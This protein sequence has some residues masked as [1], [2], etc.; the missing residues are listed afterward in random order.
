MENTKTPLE[1]INQ[2]TSLS[3]NTESEIEFNIGATERVESSNS[4]LK[5]KKSLLEQINDWTI[6]HSPVSMKEKVVF[7]RLLATMINAGVTLNKAIHILHDQT[8]DAK[9]QRV[10][11]DIAAQLEKGASLSE[12]LKI[13]PSVF[14]EAEVGMISSGEVSGKLNEVL[15]DLAQRVENSSKIKGKIRGAMMY[16]AAIVVVLIIV[17]V[18]VLVMVIPKLKDTFEKGGA[19]LPQATQ[20]LINMSESIM[21]DTYGIPNSIFWLVGIIVFFV[22][23]LAWKKTNEGKYYWDYFTLLIPVFGLLKR[24]VI[25]AQFC[26]SLSSLTK[27]GV[28]IVRTLKIIS[29]VVGNEVYRRR[30]LLIAED[31]KQGIPIADNIKEN[32]SMFPTMLTSMISVGEQTAELD[33]VSE[34]IAEFY[35]GEV[36]TMV[37]G[38]TSMMEPII[39]LVIGSVVGFIVIAIMQPIMSISEVASN[40]S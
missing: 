17:V 28:S 30:I 31:V 9:M 35:E 16:P 20:I 5:P 26:R 36:D 10:C 6:E 40:A 14:A 13:Y 22:L 3:Q 11:G 4:V 32:V 34:K 27:S 2:S 19:E 1:D 29:D 7:Y 21:G 24:K 12:A 23:F 18:L 33:H 39:I 37:K 8:K 25:L 38:L 15:S